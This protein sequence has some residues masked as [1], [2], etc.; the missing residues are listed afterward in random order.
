MK[1]IKLQECKITKDNKID[2]NK[3]NHRDNSLLFNL[4]KS[5]LPILI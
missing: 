5:F 1:E 2:K 4:I 3:L